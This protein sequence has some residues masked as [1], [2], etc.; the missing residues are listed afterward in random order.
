[1]GCTHVP[2]SDAVLRAK[3]TG[4]WTTADVT[5]PDQAKVSEVTTTFQ[6]D[7]SWYSHY[8]VSRAGDSRQQMTSGT[9][10]IDRG[11]L[12]ELQT[13]ADGFADTK[14]Q[15]GSSMVLRLDSREMVLSNWY[16]PKRV[17]LR[18]E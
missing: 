11:F 18:K 1:M 13:N 8:T 6:P 14:S 10:Q 12:I 9:W 17:F 4:T 16:A 7:G 2:E 15:S 3:V 5:L